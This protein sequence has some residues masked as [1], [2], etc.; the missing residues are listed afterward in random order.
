M[1]NEKID[2]VSIPK[3]SFWK[4]SIPIIVFTIFDAL[5]SI[6]DMVW[7]TGIS[8]EATFAL[9]ISIPFVSL[10]FSM[11]DSIGEG[12][13]SIMSRLIGAGDYESAYNALIH[14]MI[15]SNLIWI[16]MV[17]CLLFAHGTIYYL[18]EMDSYIMVFDYLVPIVVFAYMFIFINLFCETMQAEGNSDIPAILIITANV[19]NIILDPVFIFYLN[20]GLQGAA[21]AT[22]LSA[23]IVF[24]I[25]FYLYL[26]GRTKVPL[27]PKY[28][29]FRKYLLLEIFKVAFPNFINDGLWC[30]LAS[31]INATLIMTTGPMGPIL[32][33]VSNKIRSLLI[34][35]VRGYGRGLMSVTGHLFGAMKFD[36]L[37]DMYKYVL[38]ISIITSLVI[39]IV[40]D[41]FRNDIFALFSVTGMET[42]ILMISLVGTFVL[43]ITPISIIS[44]KMLDGFG[45]SV[46]SLIFSAIK[47]GIE[48]AVIYVLSN[49][50]HNGMCVLA[51]V[52]VS[53]VIIVTI[54]YNFL[55]YLFKS[56]DEEYEGKRVVKILSDG[57]VPI[58]IKESKTNEDGVEEPLLSKIPLIFAQ[59]SL[60]ITT[61]YIFY[62]PLKMEM[63]LVFASGII[64]LIGGGI[65]VYMM[66]RLHKPK[67]S[68]IGFILVAI[69]LY[70][71]LGENGYIPTIFFIITGIMILYVKIIHKRVK[72]YYKNV[73]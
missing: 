55:R 41:I 50:V 1:M 63:Y 19:L 36:E 66:K 65:S 35:P 64:A 34:A 54:Y 43:V 67:L 59:L 16:L 27:S 4:L 61:V 10:I 44:A 24:I 45:K 26:S 69:I 73:F 53:E 11:G 40:F 49:I 6:V 52:L 46:Y 71:F 72:S 9:G 5:Y 25:F 60:L 31:F 30:F 32:Y 18:D 8:V 58:S 42:E 51:G 22:V 70:I 15:A 37:N 29:K 38:K 39:M 20:M 23:S 56:F 14:G 17:L 47:I 21:Y 12:T 2:L 57:N 68:V 7:I 3:K 28:F 33:S 13:N 62:L 48:V